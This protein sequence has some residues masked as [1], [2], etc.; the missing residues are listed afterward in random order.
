MQVTPRFEVKEADR[1]GW[2]IE[3]IWP[4]GQREQLLGVYTSEE[5]A[6]ERLP[7]IS[8]QFTRERLAQGVPKNVVVS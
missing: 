2:S 1:H 5:A 4:D 6:K 8:D 7:T 3:A